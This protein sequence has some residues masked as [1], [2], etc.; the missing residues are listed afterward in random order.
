MSFAGNAGK[1]FNLIHVARRF[2]PLARFRS[3]AAG[4]RGNGLGLLAQPAQ[5]FE[6]AFLRCFTGLLERIGAAITFSANG[7]R[8]CEPSCICV[9]I[10]TAAK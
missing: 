6:H 4:I 2:A 8:T 5:P 3:Y 10:S 7:R 1:L 9:E